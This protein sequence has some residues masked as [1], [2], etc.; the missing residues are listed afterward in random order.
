MSR[1]G[2]F[3]C[4]CGTNIAGAL[5][6][7]AVAEA[8]KG[9]PGVRYATTYK[10]MCSEQGQQAVKEAIAKYELD[11][12]VIAS[13][14]PR[15]HENT[16]RKLLK[17]T[18]VNPYMLEIANIREQCAWVH[19]D[20]TEA[21]EKAIDLVRMAAAKAARRRVCRRRIPGLLCWPMRPRIL[22][23]RTFRRKSAEPT[24]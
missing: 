21:T 11:R 17:D 18:P 2:V 7:E 19:T 8:A 13:C 15:M 16:F 3:V 1:I 22:P 20:R 9:F 4:H 10:Y 23:R 24:C 14:S 6:V 12:I 5:D